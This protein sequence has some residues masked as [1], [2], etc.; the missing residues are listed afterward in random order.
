MLIRILRSATRKGI[1]ISVS[2]EM[3]VAGVILTFVTG[4]EVV[5]PNLSI[6]IRPPSRTLAVLL[7]SLQKRFREGKFF[8]IAKFLAR[9]A[10]YRLL[11]RLV[12]ASDSRVDRRI[13]FFGFEQIVVRLKE[14]KLAVFD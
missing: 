12:D 10:N 11:R 2:G 6:I 13:A 1:W 14:G 3:G 8:G 4:S 7:L 5:S 9:K